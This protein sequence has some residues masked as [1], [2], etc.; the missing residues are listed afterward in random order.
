MSAP[1]AIANAVADALGVDDVELPLTPPRVWEQLC[2]EAGAVRVPARRRPSTRRSTLL[3]EHGDEAKVLAGGQSLVPLLNM[4]FARPGARSSTSTAFPASTGSP[5]RTGIV[6]VGAL[7]RQARWSARRSLRERCPLLA[8]CAPVRRPLRDAEPRHR[9]RLDRPRGRRAELPLALVALGG[10][11]VVE[12]QRGPRRSPPTSFFVTHFTSALEPDELARR[13]GLARPR[14]PARASPSRS[15]R[16]AAAT[17]RSAWRRARCASRAAAS[18]EARIAVGAVVDRPTLVDVALAGRA[19]DADARARGRAAAPLGVEPS[20]QPARLR[21]VPDAPR[22]ACWSS[23]RSLRAW[24]R[25]GVI[26]DRASPSTAAA[27]ARRSSRACSLSDFLRHTLGL[28]GTHV[29]CEHGV[30]GACT[31]L[32]D[33]VAVRSCLLLAV[34]GRRRR[35]RDRRGARAATA[36]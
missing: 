24:E 12:S 2:G 22:P 16:C 10:S 13:D 23:A 18:R 27:T 33:G 3:A 30:C 15:S 25:R 32:L 36:S 28:T 21:R 35:A 5:R 29:G 6:R 1:V 14:G 19:V 34:A 4:R 31:V 17:T 11:A 8:E 7:V 9:R 20:G 26:R